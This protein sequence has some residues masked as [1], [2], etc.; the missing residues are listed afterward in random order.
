M[1]FV[2]SFLHICPWRVPWMVGCSRNSRNVYSL[3]W[4]H[5]S[6]TLMQLRQPKD[7]VKVPQVFLQCANLATKLGLALEP[8][9]SVN[10]ANITVVDIQ[11]NWEFSSNHESA[12]IIPDLKCSAVSFITWKVLPCN[13]LHG[14]CLLAKWTSRHVTFP[15]CYGLVCMHS[16]IH[17]TEG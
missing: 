17:L 16:L 11:Y 5:F 6:I 10:N 2:V 3:I 14:L 1:R 9:S 12:R 4:Q 8:R 15:N 13:T 7:V